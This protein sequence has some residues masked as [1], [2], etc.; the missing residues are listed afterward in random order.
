LKI[1]RGLKTN[2]AETIPPTGTAAPHLAQRIGLFDAT[3]LVIGGIVGAG[4][5][6]NPHV[7][8]NEIHAPFLILGAWILGGMIALT[9]AFIYAEL[10]AARPAVGGQYAYFK[11]AWHP[12][13]A[14]VYGWALL[15]VIQTGGMAAVS[16]TFAD[17]S[18]QMARTL[19]ASGPIEMLDRLGRFLPG[20]DLAMAG[21]AAG[22]LI[23]ILT[24]GILTVINCLGVRAGT[25][26]QT[27]LTVLKM[28]A[29]AGLVG[30][31]LVLIKPASGAP[32]FI[33]ADA[34][35]FGGLRQFG[36]AMVPVLFAYGGWQTAAFIG[37]E[38]KNPR[39]NLP[40][41]LI[42]GVLGVIV[43]YLSVNWVCL[44]ALGSSGLSQTPTPAADVARLALS[45]RGSLFISAAIIISTL[46]FLSQGMLTAPRVYFAMADDGLFFRILAR[47]HPETQVPVAAV[48][49]QGVTAVVIALSGRYEQILN[50]VISV[51][52]I[53]YGLTATC[54][55]V[56]RHHDRVAM[57]AGQGSPAREANAVGSGGAKDP[58]PTNYRVPGHPFTT[59]FFIASCWL[60]VLNLVCKY[61]KD[62]FVGL[63][64][65][66]TGIPVYLYWQ[67]RRRLPL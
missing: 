20:V 65:M 26:V 21:N 40:L 25:T 59:L 14:F 64:M 41:G 46:G 48:A 61:P 5:F 12:V 63:L 58:A 13:L 47:I 31:G 56:F 66:L 54:V 30:C 4:I 6:R 51:D 11:E 23:A 57:A 9:G 43:L 45:D 1:T 55:F 62:S 7:V 44:R 37:G 36:A 16:I 67:R 24:M 32:A 39:R 28:I 29:I 60:V 3:M 15:L 34:S 18:V 22:K 42:F 35:G 19:G 52:F 10:A 8:A 53:F 33:A 49:L 50:Y 38:V 2:T 27:T 17:Y